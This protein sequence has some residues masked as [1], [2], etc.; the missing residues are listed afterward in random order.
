MAAIC[1]ATLCGILVAGLWPFHAPTN[2][3]TWLKNENGLHF[4]D[5]GS[6]VST[7]AFMPPSSRS[8]TSCSIEIWLEPGLTEDSNTFLAFY[9]VGVPSVPLSLH[10]SISDL[11]LQR[12]TLDM[13]HRAKT[14]HFMVDDVFREKKPVFVTITSGVQGTSV[15]LNG[16]LIETSPSF[17]LSDKDFFGRLIVGNSPIGNDD[18]S[19]RLLG[20][21]IYDRELTAVQASAHYDQWTKEGQPAVAENE[22]AV[23]LY[24]FNE[25]TGSVVHNQIDPATNLLV[26]ERYFVLHAPF[27][28]PAWDE[29][30]PG[31]VYWKYVGINIAGFIP[32]GFVFCAYFSQIKRPVL[33]SIVLGFMVS[34]SIEILQAFLPTRDSGTTDIIT[35]TLGTAIGAWFCSCGA[36]Q[37]MLTR[38]GLRPERPQALDFPAGQVDSACAHTPNST[39][40]E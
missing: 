15:Y 33:A 4:G 23:G 37:A 13:N 18:W 16:A 22:N 30:Y 19:G 25:R 31:W 26:P 7:G 34:L 39:V 6:I 32:L 27:L 2:Q 5:Y 21:A 3:V 24:L 29:Y 20:L 28:L 35:N 38:V 9:S 1:A 36:L 40:Q 10:Q 12:E 17:G 11:K 8:D 14:V